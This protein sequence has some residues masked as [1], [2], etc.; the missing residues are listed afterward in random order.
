MS[1][2][3]AVS[4]GL[5]LGLILLGSVFAPS[6]AQEKKTAEPKKS[7]PWEVAK[8][9]A[10]AAKRAA[11]AFAR[12]YLEGKATVEQVER[13]SRRW[14]DAQREIS[15]K[16]SEQLAAY[17]GHVERMQELEKAAQT[18]FESKQGLESDLSV[19]EYLRLEAQMMLSRAKSSK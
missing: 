14:L 19:A 1:R 10:E 3:Y 4:A 8:A 11:K 5:V 2:R 18:K 17:E 12:E 6:P 15:S 9:K 7:M 13:W 16:R